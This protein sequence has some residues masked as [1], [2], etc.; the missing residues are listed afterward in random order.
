MPPCELTLTYLRSLASDDGIRLDPTDD[1]DLS[2]I[3]ALDH[4]ARQMR[5]GPV[6]RLRDPFLH[7]SLTYNG[8]TFRRLSIGMRDWIHDVC[9]KWYGTGPMYNASVVYCLAHADQPEFAWSFETDQSGWDRLVRGW[10][11]ACRIVQEDLTC[12]ILALYP[13]VEY[14][15]TARARE[16][17]Q[18]Y[19]PLVEML[20]RE[21]GETPE[22]WIWTAT[23]SQVETLATRY[24]ERLDAKEEAAAG[25]AGSKGIRINPDGLKQDRR[26]Q[27]FAH[28]DAIKAR[29]KSP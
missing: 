1:K 29:K 9:E 12:I 14:G 13:P 5:G 3:F 16:H 28:L 8:V 21:Y 22:H 6:E 25:A 2:D 7:P 10:M 4:Y 27:F 23:D 15:D 26:R 24:L 19:G 20:V 11:R 17:A 18:D